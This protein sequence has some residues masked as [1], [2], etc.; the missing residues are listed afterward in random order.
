VS[1]RP[2]TDADIEASREL[3]RRFPPPPFTDAQRALIVETFVAVIAD[4]TARRQPAPR[5]RTARR[6]AA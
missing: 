1:P 3:L 6:R 2:F 5:K 4:E